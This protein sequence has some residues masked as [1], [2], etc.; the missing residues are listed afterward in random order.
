M[1]ES[2]TSSTRTANASS[3]VIAELRHVGQSYPTPDGE[4][5]LQVV[6]DVSLLFDKPGINM[7]LGPSGCGKSTLLKML[8]G[9]RPFGV[10]TPTTGDVFIDGK[11]CTGSH[12]DAAM[13]FQ[14]YSNRPD[15]TVE[16]NVGYPFRF[17]LWKSQIDAAERERRV[18][19]ILQE[20]GLADKAQNLPS[21]LSGGQKSTCC[22][23]SSVGRAATHSAYGRAVWRA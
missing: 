9:V 22:P 7:V 14:S 1:S 4:G 11:P 10:Q 5:E 12:P 8:G 6:K 20:V 18:R 21:Q 16:E 17:K 19:T 23:G 3:A 13:V 2:A 15:L